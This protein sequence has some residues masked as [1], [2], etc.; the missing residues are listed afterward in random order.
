MAK[1]GAAGLALALAAA[2]GPVAPPAQA[3]KC[4]LGWSSTAKSAGAMRAAQLTGVRAGRQACYDRLVIDLRGM[5]LTGYHVSYVSSVRAEGSGKK[6]P[7]RGAADLQIVVRAPAYDSAGKPT[8]TP[9]DPKNL[10]NVADFATFRQVAWAGSFE[11]QTTIGLGVRAKLPFRV[12][13]IDDGA[14]SRLVVD[15]AHNW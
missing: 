5:Q 8:Y 9:A 6:V 14:T 4:S 13:R 7:L 12:M 2:V 1:V 11:G 10:R 15:V 3:A